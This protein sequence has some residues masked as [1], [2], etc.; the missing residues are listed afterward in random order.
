MSGKTGGQAAYESLFPDRSAY[1]WEDLDPEDAER[2]EAAAKAATVTAW[3][4][5]D[6]ARAELGN[7]RDE[8]DEMRAVRDE[9][10]RIAQRHRRER[11]ELRALLTEILDAAEYAIRYDLTP[12]MR[13]RFAQWRERTEP[14]AAITGAGTEHLAEQLAER[15]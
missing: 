10:Q 13:D 6:E 5:L 9:Y 1:G 3:R 11:D 8:L 7:A 15:Q 2:W 12:A 4:L 14:A